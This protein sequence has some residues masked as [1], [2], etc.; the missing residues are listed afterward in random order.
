MERY[1]D[2]LK[3]C[4]FCDGTKFQWQV[5]VHTIPKQY[6]LEHWCKSD[7]PGINGK[8]KRGIMLY[9]EDWDH[10]VDIWNERVGEEG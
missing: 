4:P 10:A 5:R 7:G 3:P 9:G 8:F 1:L 6:V 2:Q